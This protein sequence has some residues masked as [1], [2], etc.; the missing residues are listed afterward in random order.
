MEVRK[1]KEKISKEEIV[2]IDASSQAEKLDRRDFLKTCGKII[3]PTIGILGL[4]LATASRAVAVKSCGGTC[5]YACDGCR[6]TCE[7][8]CSGSSGS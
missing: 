7:T 8:T 1:V 2:V 5:S 4:S 6:G 3:I